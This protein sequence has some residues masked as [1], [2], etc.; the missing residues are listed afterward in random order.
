[1][2]QSGCLDAAWEHTGFVLELSG[3]AMHFDE[4]G[5]ECCGQVWCCFLQFPPGWAVELPTAVPPDEGVDANV[6]C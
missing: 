4:D 2:E 1:M 6:L 3:T 5:D